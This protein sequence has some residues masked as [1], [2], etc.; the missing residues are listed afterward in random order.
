MADNKELDEVN[1]VV[2]GE[3]MCGKTTMI[4]AFVDR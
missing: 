3:G 1:I 4:R 2:V